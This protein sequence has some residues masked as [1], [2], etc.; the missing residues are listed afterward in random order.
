MIKLNVELNI[1]HPA[2]NGSFTG[3]MQLISLEELNHNESNFNY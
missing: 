2:V 3:R 1:G